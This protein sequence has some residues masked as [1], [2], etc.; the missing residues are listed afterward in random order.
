M[1]S[2]EDLIKTSFN[3]S[4]IHAYQVNVEKNYFNFYSL[5]SLLLTK[6]RL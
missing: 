3:S 4:V 1:N 2:V 6:M 5:L